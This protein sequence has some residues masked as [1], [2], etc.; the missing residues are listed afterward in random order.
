MGSLELRRVSPA[1][2]CPGLAQSYW[3]LRPKLGTA[4]IGSVPVLFVTMINDRHDEC[5]SHHPSR[6]AEAE[7]GRGSLSSPDPQKA[8]EFFKPCSSASTVPDPLTVQ[9]VVC[10][11]APAMVTFEARPSSTLLAIVRAA[12]SPSATRHRNSE[13]RLGH[14][15]EDE[16][17]GLQPNLTRTG[18]GWVRHPGVS[19]ELAGAV[20]CEPHC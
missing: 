13:G 7:V 2:S 8:G 19:L 11:T 16:V 15:Q 17:E 14:S 20:R 12:S 4:F 1:A 3:G 18:L 6:L 9:Q 10:V 5:S